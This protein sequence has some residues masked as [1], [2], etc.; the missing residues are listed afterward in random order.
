MHLFSSEKGEVIARI[1][2]AISETVNPK[3]VTHWTDF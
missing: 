2:D 1:A 3:H